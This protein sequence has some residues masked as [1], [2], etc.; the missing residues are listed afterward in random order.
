MIKLLFTIAVRNFLKDKVLSVI[1]LANLAI[2]FAAFILIS[3]YIHAEY[4]WDKHNA[5]Y[6]RIYR[7]QMFMDQPENVIK[8]SWSVTPALGRNDIPRLSEVEKVALIHDVGDNNK[9]GVFLSVDK[10][11]EFFCRFG[12]YADPEIFDII[13][14]KFLVGLPEEALVKSYSILLSKSLAQKLFPNG[15]ELGATV[16]GENKVALTLTGVY[17]DLPENS[18]WRPTFIIPMN[19][20]ALLTDW[21]NFESDYWGYSFYTYVLLKKGANPESVDRKIYNALGKYRK[22]HHPYLR[23]IS[24]LHLNPHFENDYATPKLLFSLITIL[25]LVL[26]SINFINLQTANSLTRL[27]EIGIKKT[28]GFAKK[29]LWLQ[30]IFESL[31]VA[32]VAGFL[33]LFMAELAL[34]FFNHLIGYE[35]APHV[36]SFAK[37]NGI[38]FLAVLLTGVL[39]G[40]Y[41]SYVIS[42]FNPLFAIQQKQHVRL[43]GGVGMKKVLVA[44]QFCISIFLLIVSFI[45]YRQTNYMI[46]KDMGFDSQNIITANIITNNRAPFDSLRDKLLLHKEIADAC[47]SDFIPFVLPGGNDLTWE[48]ARPNELIFVR[49]YYVDYNFLSTF[50]MQLTEGRNFSRQHKDDRNIC[51]INE[52]AA[53]MFR[54]DE[55]LGKHVIEYNRNVKVVGVV[56]DFIASSTHMLIEPH[57]Y[58]LMDSSS[59]LNKI[60]SIRYTPGQYDKA[61][62]IATAE[63]RSFYPDDVVE[64]KHIRESMKD[65]DAY[66]AWKTFRNVILLFTI[67]SIIISSVGLYGLVMFFTKQKMK[68]IGIRKVLGFSLGRLYF[69]LSSEFIG[70]I[71]IAMLAAWPLGWYAHKLLPGAYKYPLSI[72]EFLLA[73]A[74][75]LLVALATISY[76]IVKSTRANPVEVLKY[77]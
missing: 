70:L 18:I 64:F 5:N 46:N 63:F 71:A 1:N 47:V 11:N 50:R 30:F 3:L 58:L 26:S 10:K 44:F 39:S 12:Y 6:D 13:T 55:P 8:H 53:R 7:L 49:Y 24:Q 48:D 41:P 37:L 38:I 33:A 62:Q 25:V 52:T 17:D 67:L 14:F 19:T 72:W 51:L 4:S 34:P 21:K 61:K 15:H 20:F 43:T 54:W 32:V 77:E 29:S 42:K 22:E 40:L 74:I 76:H 57:M 45:T 60:Y 31:L 73:T 23:H 69:K 28:I 2:G 56:K 35:I 27:R 16:Y 75:I 66:K 68:E 59:R 65:E 9:N 36:L